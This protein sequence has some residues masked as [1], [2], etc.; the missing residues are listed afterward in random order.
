MD[1][2]LLPD[3]GEKDPNFTSV[4]AKKSD[5]SA[6][7]TLIEVMIVVVILG[8]IILAALWAYNK[9][10]SK[11]Y[12]AKRKDDLQKI[13]K[14]FE[15]YYNDYDCYPEPG[16]LY[17]CGEPL[18]G[19]RSDVNY[20][21]EIPC[22]PKTNE[23]YRV[24]TLNG[25]QCQGVKILAKL[26]N[27]DDKD[28]E[29]AGCNAETGCGW[30][31]HP[32]YNYGEVLGGFMT[33]DAW[34]QPGEGQTVSGYEEGVIGHY[35]SV[36]SAGSYSCMLHENKTEEDFAAM[37]CIQVFA[38]PDLTQ[39]QVECEAWHDPDGAFEDYGTCQ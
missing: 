8:I 29:T 9:Q 35:A 10:L 27:V 21:Q 3:K 4:K 38:S 24:L 22:D 15:E 25:D 23:P 30:E 28:I 13:V 6:G 32:E 14:A 19:E 34:Q 17:L 18:T 37:G 26:S 39:G 7:I 11:A 1:K 31:G 5:F 12:D 20:L 2:K 33:S 16:V 36:W